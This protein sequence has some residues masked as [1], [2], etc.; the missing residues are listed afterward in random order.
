MQSFKVTL[1]GDSGVGKTNLM[2][3]FHGEDY[4]EEITDPV[5]HNRSN[6]ITIQNKEYNLAVYDTRGSSDFD[7]L[8]PLAYPNTDT[9]IICFSIVSP[10]SFANIKTKWIPEITKY[11]PGTPFIIIGTKSDL[12]N[13]A[14]TLQ[15]LQA[16]NESVVTQQQGEN[17]VAEQCTIADINTFYWECSSMAGEGIEHP[18][19][20]ALSHHIEGVL[21]TPEGWIPMPRRNG[22]CAMI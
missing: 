8:R 2:D 11:C 16:N 4:K 22:F 18:F 20:Q 12:R 21:Y 9:F 13:D 10:R 5:P 7:K 17:L 3:V 14:E 6:T 19:H 15:Q 1:V